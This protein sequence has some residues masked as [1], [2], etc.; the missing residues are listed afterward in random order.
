MDSK[1]IFFLLL[2]PLVA[3]GQ[4]D[5]FRATKHRQ[6]EVYLAWEPTDGTVEIEYVWQLDAA[7][8]V[9]PENVTGWTAMTATTN[10]GIYKSFTNSTTYTALV[11]TDS[12]AIVANLNN[13]DTDY[14]HYWFRIRSV[15]DSDTGLQN[16]SYS[17]PARTGLFP[18]D[19]TDWTQTAFTLSTE[20]ADIGTTRVNAF[21]VTERKINDRDRDGNN[22]RLGV[23]YPKLANTLILIDDVTGEH[24]EVVWGYFSSWG[25]RV[26]DSSPLSGTEEGY[27]EEW[28]Y[29]YPKTE[30]DWTF[31]GVTKET[32]SEKYKF[33]RF[34]NGSA[35]VV[36]DLN[37]LG[38]VFNTG[39]GGSAGN[40]F[41]KDEQRMSWDHTYMSAELYDIP[42]DSDFHD[43]IAISFRLDGTGTP[44]ERNTGL[45]IWNGQIDISPKGDFVIAN[46]SYGSG[47]SEDGNS[48]LR[49]VNDATLSNPTL[50][51]DNKTSAGMGHS[52]NAITIQ[53][54]QCVVGDITTSEGS[55]RMGMYL[56]EGPNSGQLFDI[57][58]A[59]PG[60]PAIGYMNSDLQL[61][62]G[63]IMVLDE[64]G[65]TATGDNR[66]YDLKIW[67]MQLDESVVERNANPPIREFGRFFDVGSKNDIIGGIYAERYAIPNRTGKRIFFNADVP[68]TGE[69]NH[70][71]MYV[72]EQTT[73]HGDEIGLDPVGGGDV[74]APVPSNIAAEDVV[75]DEAYI[76][77]SWNEPATG[78]VNYGKTPALGTSTTG[79]SEYLLF[80]R[81][82]LPN[83]DSGEL[84]YYE[85]EG[86]DQSANTG[87]ST[88]LK[89]FTTT[90]TNPGN[91]FSVV[92]KPGAIRTSSGAAA[93]IVH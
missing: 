81:Q 39:P 5:S 85:V 31:W 84:Y 45:D 23:D 6:N 20:I 13:G 70:A 86:D 34:N 2:L 69:T 22:K 71:E 14:G 53:G 72:L 30:S 80:H 65:G 89:T 67:M 38:Y 29:L 27:L 77:W 61:N 73:L 63:W 43:A 33:K 55:Q 36:R 90:T 8:W 50:I 79:S 56:L 26:A 68:L 12:T 66:R 74:T 57:A 37:S 48:I 59:A 21:G 88:P 10:P 62:P 58:P 83:L 46:S 25:W 92:N 35:T 91:T 52:V 75:D 1:L 18:D 28:P 4:F 41:R 44:W 49:M 19:L 15:G 3:F 17:L 47:Q 42:P 93:I 76:E 78:Q 82:L 9:D 87:T 51:E 32:E 7:G 54:N 64:Y 40:P 16:W 24:Y 60:T 11:A